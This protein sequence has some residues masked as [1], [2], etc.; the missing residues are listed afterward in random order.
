MVTVSV[1]RGAADLDVAAGLLA[2][3]FAPDPL[4]AAVVPGSEEARRGRLRRYYRGLLRGSDPGRVVDLARRR[5]GEVVGVAIWHAPGVAEREESMIDRV[6]MV[7]ALGRSG[8]RGWQRMEQ[9]FAAVRPTEPHWYLSDV[10]VSGRARGE[11]VGSTLLGHRLAIA[12]AEHAPAYLEATTPG[13][14]RMYERLGFTARGPVDGLPVGV[15]PPER[16]WRA[17]TPR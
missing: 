12:D 13:S 2:E 14:R 6:R 10:V 15:H 1:A 16:M 11:G 4:I 3:G 5:S 9:A 7:V 8:A 17:A